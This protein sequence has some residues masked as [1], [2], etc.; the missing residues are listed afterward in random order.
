[1][2]NT[3]WRDVVAMLEDAEEQD[4][5]RFRDSENLAMLVDREDFYLTGEYVDKITDPDD[6]EVK[7][8]RERR[9]RAGIK[10]PPV[11]VLR[12]IALRRA[13]LTELRTEQH[14]ALMAQFTQPRAA[15]PDDR[16]SADEFKRLAD[17]IDA[18]Q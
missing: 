13:D 17:R 15:A 5:Q 10:P 3:Y 8:A 4:Q 1:M 9:K 6:P 11:P 14:D 2:A 18:L 12:P 16:V 7:A